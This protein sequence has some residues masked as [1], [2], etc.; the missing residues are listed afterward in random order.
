MR[1]IAATLLS[2]TLGLGLS[3]TATS[4]M[5]PSQNE[6]TASALGS[7]VTHTT[8]IDLTAVRLA[9]GGPAIATQELN[10]ATASSL[11][12]SVAVLPSFQQTQA[13][14]AITTGVSAP[15]G[16]IVIDPSLIVRMAAVG[17]TYRKQE[18]PATSS[19]RCKS[20]THGSLALHIMGHPLRL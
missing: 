14:N 1:L 18:E 7:P 9:L 4:G 8:D 6:Q 12:N 11:T 20:G 3:S 10:S 13:Q 17:T 19:Q 2:L 15:T 16:T 5:A